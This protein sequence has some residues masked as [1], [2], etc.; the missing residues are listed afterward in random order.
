MLIAVALFAILGC[1]YGLGKRFAPS[2]VEVD[3]APL[4]VEDATFED[5]TLSKLSEALNLTEEQIAS[6]RPEI[7]AT[8]DK[9]T[10]SRKK[11]LFEF[12][13]HIRELHEKM[14]PKL[15]PE[16]QEKLK[17]SRDTLQK[18]IEKRFPSLLDELDSTTGGGSENR[19]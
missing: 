9:I 3:P 5:L 7:E 19:D 16:Q 18:V 11:A 15:D 6:I 8:N 4:V 14:G 17:K 2:A 12:Y 13:L 10:A 1:G